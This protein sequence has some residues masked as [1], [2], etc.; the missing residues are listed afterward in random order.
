MDIAPISIG[1]SKLC[2]HESD[3]P[4]PEIWDFASQPRGRLFQN[5]LSTDKHLDWRVYLRAVG[6]RTEVRHTEALERN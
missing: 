1:T 6:T 4:V 2:I 5:K 3:F